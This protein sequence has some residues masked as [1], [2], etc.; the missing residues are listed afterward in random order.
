MEES[1]G[2]INEEHIDNDEARGMVLDNR[3]IQQLEEEI[4]ELKN[5][6]KKLKAQVSQFQNSRSHSFNRN[7]RRDNKWTAEEG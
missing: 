3:Y 5:M 1:P 2:K 6:N 4:A 7:I